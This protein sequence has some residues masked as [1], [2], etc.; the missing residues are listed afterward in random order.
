VNRRAFLGTAAGGFLTASRSVR[1]QPAGKVFRI[2]YL[3][4]NTADRDTDLRAA[5]QQGLAELGYLEGKSVI[6]EYRYAAADFGRLPGLAAELA[7]AKVDVV[8]A[9][10]TAVFLAK[11]ALAGVPTVFVIAEDP[12]KAGLVASLAQPGGHMTGL[13]S[14]NIELEGKR[15]EILKAALP[16]V[17]R[18]GLLSATQDPSQRDRLAAVEQAARAL[19][20]QIE[21]LPVPSMDQ[22]ARAVDTA[23]RAAV[24]AIMVVGAPVF[25]AYSAQTAQLVAK[26]RLPA[27]SAWREFAVAG[28]LL[29]YGTSVPAMFRRAAL[30]VDKILKGAKPGDLPVEQATTFE[31]V[32]NLKRAKALGLTLSQPLLLR[33]DE[34]IQ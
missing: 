5:F 29:S 20:V 28:G 10:A 19:E 11:S 18:I 1:A 26:T 13:S 22:I 3:T 24:E 12:V 31:L 16:A 34:V 6:V 33:A 7:R 27:A 25:R 2:G 14:L 32:I 15:L 9:S 30:F 23:T 21:V 4:G 8:V 17:R